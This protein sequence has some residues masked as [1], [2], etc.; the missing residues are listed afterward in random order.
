MIHAAADSAG[1]EVA[2]AGE[3]WGAFVAQEEIPVGAHSLLF[4]PDGSHP[5]ALGTHLAASAFYATL[6]GKSPV[7][8][9]TTS[10][11]T[12]M[13]PPPGPAPDVKRE[14]IDSKFGLIAQ[15]LAWKAARR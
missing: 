4:D 1:A 14:R 15:E 8:L 9:P 7:G 11:P 13:Q 3:A 6:Y 5:T 10:R 12:N 2:H